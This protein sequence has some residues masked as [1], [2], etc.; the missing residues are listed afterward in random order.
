MFSSPG[1]PNTHVTPSCSRQR[2]RRSATRRSS[3]MPGVYPAPGVSG[4]R[5]LGW[6]GVGGEVLGEEAGELGPGRPDVLLFVVEV[7]VAG[8]VD[9][10]EILS[11]A[12]V[13]RGP[14]AH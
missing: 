12:G 2:T 5:R 6:R 1:M 9:P 13:L 11:A 3:A 8:A 14:D 4:G 10:V 7:V